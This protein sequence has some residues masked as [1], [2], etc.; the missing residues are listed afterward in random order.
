M[1]LAEGPLRAA[2][3]AELAEH[4]TGVGA[5]PSSLQEIERLRVFGLLV[6]RVA[7]AA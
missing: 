2:L 5:P 3:A 7:L 6:L 1:L 4:A